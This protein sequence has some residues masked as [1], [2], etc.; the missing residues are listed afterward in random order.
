MRQKRNETKVVLAKTASESLR[1]TIPAHIVEILGLK[2]GDS[3][4]WDFSTQDSHITVT[5]QKSE[6]NNNKERKD[7][8]G[9]EKNEIDSK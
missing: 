6:K 3:L 4:R 2:G 5:L 8:Q 7:I 9:S 1:T